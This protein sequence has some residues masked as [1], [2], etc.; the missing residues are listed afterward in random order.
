MPLGLGSMLGCARPVV[1]GMAVYALRGDWLDAVL[2]ESLDLCKRVSL[3][4]G[5]RNRRTLWVSGGQCV[6]RDAPDSQSSLPV[7]R[8]RGRSNTGRSR[9]PDA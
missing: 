8:N 7:R 4:I 6:P 2:T 3:N 9:T 1:V 5:E